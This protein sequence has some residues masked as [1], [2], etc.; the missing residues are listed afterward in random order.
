MVRNNRQEKETVPVLST[1]ALSRLSMGEVIIKRQRMNPIDTRF[2]SFD[3]YCFSLPDTSPLEERKLPE[4]MI[5]S[6]EQEFLTRNP[7][8]EDTAK[9][10]M[11]PEKPKDDG[12]KKNGPDTSDSKDQKKEEPAEDDMTG[13]GLGINER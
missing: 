12:T 9:I 10:E 1:D 13:D 3:R 5:Y 2:R 8:G 11:T 6:L 7:A 4:A